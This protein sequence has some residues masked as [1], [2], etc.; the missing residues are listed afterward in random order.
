M[1]DMYK[2]GYKHHMR[3]D[4]YTYTKV[5]HAWSKMGRKGSVSQAEQILSKM[6]RTCLEQGCRH[7]CKPNTI[8][9]NIVIHALAK[10]GEHGAA[11]RAQMYLDDM[12]ERFQTKGET[13]VRPNTITFNAVMDA[14]GTQWRRQSPVDC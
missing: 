10:S 6:E 5:I 4:V 11:E 2:K 9:Y 13:F 12:L 7:Y 8:T 3:P 14:F 1:E